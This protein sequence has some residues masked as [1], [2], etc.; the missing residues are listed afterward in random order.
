MTDSWRRKLEAG[1]ILVVDGATGTELR[2]RGVTPDDAAWSAPAALTHPDVLTSIHLDYIRAG[3]EVVTTNTFA[4]SRFVLDA[5]GLGHRF[6]ELNRAAVSAAMRAREIAA[7]DVAIAG[8]ISCLPPRFDVNAYPDATA[9]RAAYAELAALLA[10]LGVDLLALEMME[11]TE[12]APRACEAARDTGLPFW[13][14]VSARLDANGRLVAYDFPEIPLAAVLDALLVY[15]P[16]VVNVMHTPPDAV[17]PALA[18]LRARGC[19]VIGAYPELGGYAGRRVPAAEP[20]GPDRLAALAA[21]W[22]AAGARVIGGC[23][24]TRP[25]HV[26]ALREAVERRG[27]RQG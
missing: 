17:A 27:R 18:A 7:A 16:D 4:A 2:R 8:S 26:R 20:L 19:A 10:D 24:G 14:G 13:I 5:A 22:I 12:H 1:G 3:A 6:E 9:E 23:C 25:A 21:E 11:D 15:A